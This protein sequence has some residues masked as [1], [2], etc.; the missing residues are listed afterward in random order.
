M[1]GYVN[2]G[3]KTMN[4]IYVPLKLTFQWRRPIIKKNSM[5]KK[6]FPLCIEYYF[7]NIT[8]IIL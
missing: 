6:I 3:M 7:H 1:R 4:K 8:V 5:D 2:M